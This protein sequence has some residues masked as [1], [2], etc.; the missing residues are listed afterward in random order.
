MAA[1]FRGA[2]PTG[3][4]WS[5]FDVYAERPPRLIRARRY[6]PRDGEDAATVLYLHGGGFSLGSLESHHDVCLGVSDGTGLE[7]VAI[8]YRLAPEY[9]HSAQSD[10][11]E[12]AYRL[13]SDG[14][15]AILVAGDSAGGNLAAGICLR[16]RDYGYCAPL[17]QVLIY[18][19]LGGDVDAGSYVE[20]AEAPLLSRA[21]CLL[22]RKVRTG[23]DR[24]PAEPDPDLAPLASR[25]FARLPPAFIVSADID[26]LRGDSR[27]YVENLRAAGVAAQWRNELQLV[28][29]YLRARHSCARA[30]RSF[31]A[32]VTA[33]R[34]FARAAKR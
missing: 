32:I 19:D 6:R 33:I 14:G 4:T 15:R 23:A 18:P 8:D 17:A 21:D 5:D 30:A 9:I 28:H 11:C 12:A 10:D 2:P 16:A 13:L 3:V 31:A 22:Y 25:S 7:V 26:P 27:S 20:N 1:A 29:G 24:R 34:D